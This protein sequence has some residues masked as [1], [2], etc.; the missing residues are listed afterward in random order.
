MISLHRAPGSNGAVERHVYVPVTFDESYPDLDK[1]FHSPSRTISVPEASEPR[2]SRA[3][4]A[5][6]RATYTIP[7]D[8]VAVLRDAYYCTTNNVVLPRR[9]HV[10]IESMNGAAT[11][12]KSL[13]P[14][15]E[16]AFDAVE[17]VDGFATLFD[18]NFSGY[19]HQI[20]EMV[21]RLLA[22]Y[23]DPYTHLADLK[24]ICSR[25]IC[26]VAAFLLSQLDRLSIRPVRPAAGRILQI[27]RLLFTPFKSGQFA[28]YLPTW[29]VSELRKIIFP[30]RAPR[31]RHR[32]FIS[33]ERSQKRRI[34]N[35]E[36]F[37]RA[38]SRLGFQTYVLEDMTPEEQIDLFYDAEVVVG[39]H[40]A[41][42]TNVLFSPHVKVL[43]LFPRDFI[44]PHYLF[45]CKSL[46]HEYRMWTNANCS[47]WDLEYVT[48]RLQQ[49]LKNIPMG[50]GRSVA[51]VHG[52]SINLSYTVDV[53]AVTSILA[54]MGIR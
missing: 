21:P 48:W 44:E 9:G 35:K 6:N 13:A 28:G 22:L 51:P 5:L 12:G 40:G 47:R 50:N 36:S 52:R 41:G 11:F 30:P 25:E 2:M 3:S 24:L 49:R 23:R 45:L 34:R 32:I 8:Y 33:R 18:S 1:E 39:T 10:L 17:R 16:S 14:V 27:D 37:K 38:L 46:G 42:L 31:P 54:T 7:E 43:E 53:E 4:G 15:P 20:V 26:S 29:Y 19:Y